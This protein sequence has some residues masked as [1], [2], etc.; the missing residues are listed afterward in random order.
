[1][2]NVDKRTSIVLVYLENYAY[3]NDIKI[4]HSLKGNHN[5]LQ[6]VIKRN[7]RKALGSRD[8]ASLAKCEEREKTNKIQQLDVCDSILQRSAPQPLPTTCSR[9]RAVHQM[10]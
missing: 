3:H 1:M 6:R 10:Q 4:R 7:E 2:H 5:V 8:H 9:N